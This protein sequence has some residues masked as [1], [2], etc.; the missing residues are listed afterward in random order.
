VGNRAGFALRRLTVTVSQTNLVQFSVRRFFAPNI[1]GKGRLLRG[2]TG[3]A[4]LAVAVL[5]CDASLWL[6]FALAVAGAFALF[7][8]FRGWCVARACGIKTKL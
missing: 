8:A 5:A 3:M 1:E 6:A 4:L 2:L 7:E